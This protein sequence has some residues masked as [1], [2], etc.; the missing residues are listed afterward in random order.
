MNP[1]SNAGSRLRRA[2]KRHARAAA[3]GVA[4]TAAAVAIVGLALPASAAPARV[5][6]TEH[7]QIM[8]TTTNPNSTTNP[9]IAYGLFTAAGVDVQNSSSTDTFYFS[10]GHFL[11]RHAPIKLTEHQT[12]N[13]KTCFFSYSERGTFKVGPGTGRYW[14][15]SGGGTYSLSVIGIGARLKNGACNMSQNARAVAQQQI[16]QAAGRL[17]L[18]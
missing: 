8:N 18:S 7:F 2:A 6:G 5:W 16:I 11:V 10:N 17:S 13:P 12:F 1:G 15:I 9:L 3:V 4:G 14:G